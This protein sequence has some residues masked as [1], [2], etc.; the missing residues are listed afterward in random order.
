M[1]EK[2]SRG[3]IRVR[4]YLSWEEPQ[5]FPSF[6]SLSLSLSSSLSPRVS[7]LQGVKKVADGCNVLL[8][9]GPNW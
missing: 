9:G 3:E 2:G 8:I 1:L 6:L 5:D 4:I 7:K